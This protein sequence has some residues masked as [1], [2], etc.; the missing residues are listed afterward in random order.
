MVDL[1]L[2]NWNGS[3][4][5]PEPASIDLFSDASNTGY[6]GFMMEKGKRFRKV[7]QGHWSREEQELST[8]SRE[9]IAAQRVVLAFLKWRRLFGV[10]IRLFTDNVVTYTYINHMGGRYSHLREIASKMLRECERR[11]VKLMVEHL[12]R[13]FLAS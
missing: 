3:A 13:D 2:K 12:P 7:V 6:G 8:N 1:F 9:L 5:I 11:K 10:A 4:I